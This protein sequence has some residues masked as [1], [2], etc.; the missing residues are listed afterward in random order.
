[1]VVEEQLPGH[2]VKLPGQHAFQKASDLRLIHQAQNLQ[3]AEV[4]CTNSHRYGRGRS[5]K[6]P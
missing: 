5:P 6:S 2:V 3:L 4:L 1:M